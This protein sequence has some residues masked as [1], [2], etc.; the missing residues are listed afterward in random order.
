V[1]L[2]VILIFILV[3]ILLCAFLVYRSQCRKEAFQLIEDAIAASVKK[4]LDTLALKYLHLVRPDEYKTVSMVPW[5]KHLKRFTDDVVRPDLPR[6]ADDLFTAWMV[7]RGATFI[8]EIT[9]LIRVK[10]ESLV[11]SEDKVQAM[12]GIEFEAFSMKRL[13][14]AGWEVTSTKASGDQGVD[15]LARKKGLS[16]AIQCKRAA[17]P[18]GNAAVQEAL[19]GSKHFRT[20]HAAVISNSAYTNAAQELAYSTNVLLLHYSEITKLDAILARAQ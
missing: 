18:V 8:S 12:S 13:H 10:S 11:D 19:A 7:S 2:V 5:A 20:Q 14:D 9:G 6:G 1:V 15:I 17:R 3:C 16:I 4:H